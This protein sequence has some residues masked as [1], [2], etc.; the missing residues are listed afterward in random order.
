MA[1]S[2]IAYAAEHELVGERGVGTVREQV[3]ASDPDGACNAVGFNRQ[4]GCTFIVD[5]SFAGIILLWEEPLLA[6]REFDGFR[7]I[8]KS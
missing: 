6:G 8:L 3:R 7:R 4:P 5:G 2:A 1:W